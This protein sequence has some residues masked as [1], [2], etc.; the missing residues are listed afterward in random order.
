MLSIY[1]N[2]TRF[3]ALSP[4]N[5]NIIELAATDTNA[6]MMATY[7]ARN[8]EAYRRLVGGGQFVGQFPDGH[9]GQAYEKA[10]ELYKAEAATNADFKKLHDSW[11]KFRLDVVHWH[12]TAEAAMQ[13]AI[14]KRLIR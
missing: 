13:N 10:N 14:A 7:D 2:K 8:A 3:D 5:K 4:H 11:R 9:L 1:I 12:S 6:W